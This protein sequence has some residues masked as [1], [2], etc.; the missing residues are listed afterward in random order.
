[1]TLVKCLCILFL[2]HL[3]SCQ[4]VSEQLSLSGAWHPTPFEIDQEALP[5]SK[6]SDPT[7]LQAV[8]VECNHRF[9][10]QV[11]TVELDRHLL[12][13]S[14]IRPYLRVLKPVA[15]D[16]AELEVAR[17]PCPFV[18]QTVVCNLPLFE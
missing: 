15:K 12:V 18:Y 5:L 16:E 2:F 6:P 13:L 8:A 17:D 11:L 10:V 7:G 3:K 1:M 4:N 14:F 9:R